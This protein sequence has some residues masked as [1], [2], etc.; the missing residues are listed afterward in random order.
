MTQGQHWAMF[1]FAGRCSVVA[2]AGST[3]FEETEMG[4]HPDNVCS[5]VPILRH[6]LGWGWGGSSQGE[7]AALDSGRSS[8]SL[9][10]SARGHSLSEKQQMFLF[11]KTHIDFPPFMI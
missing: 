2:R 9:M 4:V 6:Y 11:S 1:S 8:A 7:P 3:A 10:D 5:L